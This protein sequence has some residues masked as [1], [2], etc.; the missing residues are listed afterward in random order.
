MSSYCVPP[1]IVSF[2]GRHSIFL[3][4]NLIEYEHN[5]MRPA[6]VMHLRLYYNPGTLCRPDESHNSRVWTTNDVP[7]STCQTQARF[8]ERKKLERRLAIDRKY[9]SA[10]DQIES[11]SASPQSVRSQ[12]EKILFTSSV[13]YHYNIKPIHS[14]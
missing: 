14:Q 6:S 10:H 12:V 5:S 8:L 13:L 7:A 3:A 4:I 2:V 1:S 11:T 9:R